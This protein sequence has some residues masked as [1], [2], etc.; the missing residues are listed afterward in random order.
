MAAQ[1]KEELIAAAAWLDSFTGKTKDLPDNVA[2]PPY[3]YRC[4]TTTV[5][6]LEH[7]SDVGRI[8]QYYDGNERRN[9]TIA[10]HHMDKE[11][12]RE[13]IVT[14][15]SLK[16][17]AERHPEITEDKLK[18][19]LRSIKRVGESTQNKGQLITLS[20]NGV[21]LVFRDNVVWTAF[22]PKGN[23]L[24]YFKDSSIG[25]FKKWKEKLKS[26]YELI[27]SQ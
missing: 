7:M 16:H 19:A 15:G 21:I 22:T 20:E 3:H 2:S 6:Y 25:G 5:A 27:L 12:G 26:I 4:R 10:F 11:L 17:I 14:D 13:F 24:K 1:T 23:S 9:E 18:A 8:Y